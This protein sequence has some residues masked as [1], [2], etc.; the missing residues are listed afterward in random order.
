M[1]RVAANTSPVMS[2]MAIG[3]GETSPVA[4][5]TTLETEIAR[6]A[7]DTAGGI[8]TAN[9]V[10]YSATYGTGVGTGALTEAGIFNAAS[11]GT[12]LCRTTFPVLNK[13][14]NDTISIS[15]VVSIT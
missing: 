10:A 9:T 2:H 5:D 4:G 14:S 11:D 15:W 7:V 3:E 1:S 13:G 8:A 12:M 6:V